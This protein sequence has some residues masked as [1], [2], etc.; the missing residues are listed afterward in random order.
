MTQTSANGLTLEYETFGQS[1]NPTILLVMGL[2]TQMI[3]WPVSFCEA[4][5]AK[6][7]HVVRF[8]NRDCGLSSKLDRF[9]PASAVGTALR[10]LVGAKPKSAYRLRD[11]ADDAFGLL[12]ALQI[13]K[14]HIVGVS[15]GGMIAQHM[16]ASRPERVL[17]L[18]SWMSTT[19]A[20]RLPGPTWAVSRHL[21]L[22]RPKSTE[23]QVLIDYYVKTLELI[24]S[25]GFPQDYRPM[26]EAAVTRMI[27]PDGF[28]RQ[29]AAIIADGNRREML[30][31]IRVPSL[32][33]HGDSD[34]LIPLAGGEDT[35]AHVPNAQLE[36]VEGMGHDLP[37]ALMPRM[38]ELIAGH[39]SRS[40]LATS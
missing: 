12:D 34:P 13:E 2:A 37:E 15:M 32:V 38:A 36:I 27:H 33:I 6:G 20:R 23:P 29:L 17:S 14:A 5:A 31:T 11:M 1:E 40:A 26:A 4:L 3:A 39:A 8:D 22:T 7:F 35:A 25:A 28:K 21:F 16:A 9:P 30:A 19:G 10:A 18:T 24:G